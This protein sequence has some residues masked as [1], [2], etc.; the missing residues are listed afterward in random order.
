MLP[1]QATYLELL[2]ASLWEREAVVVAP[3]DWPAVVALAQRQSTLCLVAHAAFQLDGPLQPPA[4]W[5]SQLQ[6][7]L[8]KTVN[9]HASTN[10]MIARMA[11]ALQNEDIHPVLLKGQGMAAYYHQPLLRQCGDI[12]LYVG[13]ASYEQACRIVDEQAKAFSHN[14]QTSVNSSAV[15]SA[16]S[17]HS[18]D[19]HYAVELGKGLSLE[20]HQYTEKLSSPK[21]DAVYQQISDVGTSQQLVPMTFDGVEVMTPSDDFN[22]FYVFHHLWHHVIGMGLGQRQLCDWAV[23]LHTHAGKLDVAKLELWLK[24]MDLLDIWRVFGCMVVRHLGLP[25]E[26]MPFYDERLHRRAD[27]LLTY[28]LREGNN[29]DFKYGRSEN[30]LLRK[31]ATFRYIHR[32]LFRLLPIFPA[33]AL[34]TYRHELVEAARKIL[35]L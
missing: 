5:Q 30:P 29:F 19:K 11:R 26:E 35:V 31:T 27:R 25:A 24:E 15:L 20:L 13:V 3:I 1:S 34:R 10:R 23:F 28:M 21:R 4:A 32:K 16:A 7:Q 6:A 12:D 14:L 22:A 2:R 17:S 9:A 8:M 18:T 33:V